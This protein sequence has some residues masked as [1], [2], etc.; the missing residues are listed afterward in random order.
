M[1]ENVLERVLSVPRSSIETVNRVDTQ[2]LMFIAK[3]ASKRT[4]AAMAS[5]RDLARAVGLSETRLRLATERLERGG[6]IVIEPCFA[7]DG[8]QRPNRYVVTPAGYQRIRMARDRMQ[9]ACD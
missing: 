5:R 8:G 2:L 9:R 3:E 1:Q 6:Y 7:E 4:H